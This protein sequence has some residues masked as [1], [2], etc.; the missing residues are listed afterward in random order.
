MQPNLLTRGTRD[1]AIITGMAAAAGYGAATSGH[2][3]LAALP[4]ADLALPELAAAAAA[5]AARRAVAPREHESRRRATLRLAASAAAAVT[6][7]GLAAR[8]TAGL[9]ATTSRSRLGGF[10][11]TGASAAI[12]V[13]AAYAATRP[14]R[15]VPGSMTTSATPAE[16]VTRT[17]SGPKALAIAGGITGLLLGVAHVESLVSRATSRAAARVLGGAPQDHRAI[18]RVAALAG[19]YL[20]ARYA[21]SAVVAKLN[22]AGESV[23]AAHQAAPD[24]PEVTGSPQSHIPWNAQSREGRRWLSMVLR[25]DN[26]AAIMREPASQPIRIYASLD[27]ATSDEARAQLLLRELDRTRALE[28][29]VVALFSPTGS[30]YVNYVACES[31]EYLSR[32]DCASMCI[33]YSVLPSSLSLTAVP[34]GT[35]QTRLVLDG[36]TERLLAMESGRRPQF[37]IFGESLGSQVSQ[38]M[39]TGQGIAGLRAAGLD[40][41]IWIGTPA[42]TKWR[43]ELWGNRS[44]AEPPSLGPDAAYLP[45]DVLDWH[46]LPAER[47]AAVRYLLLQNG[48]DPVPKF[49]SQVL[50]EQPDWL[51]P[52]PQRPPG[53][54]RGSR[55][56]PLVTF[57]ATFVDLMNALSPVPGVFAE[58]GHDYRVE[59]PEA[60]RTVW[61]LAVTGEQMDRV[62]H[63]LRERELAWEA[64]RKWQ[65]AEAVPDAGARAAAEQKTEQVVGEWINRRPDT[66]MTPDQIEE[67]IATEEPGSAQAQAA[68]AALGEPWQPPAAP[69]LGPDDAADATADPGTAR[70]DRGQPG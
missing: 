21:I 10:V 2:A 37:V 24:L 29:S 31:L 63:A 20:A 34:L 39:F 16:D 26:I 8:A 40:A 49:G 13:V 45:R 64:A 46:G 12:A 25:R 70:D 33:E 35:R 68:A 9:V 53:A 17:T 36:I 5:L 41:A 62:Q 22:T 43:R 66:P 18:G 42:S 69:L 58:G 44:V 65:A 54:P 48:D 6:L 15:C 61:R 59:I 55:W 3:V 28:R 7:S 51:G 32:G 57:V 14:D 47:R 30:G 56:V 19:S 50:W 67:I 27:S 52:D 23:E 4:G 1:Q 60:V 38:D 11:L